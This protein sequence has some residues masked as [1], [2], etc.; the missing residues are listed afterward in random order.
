[1]QS[2]VSTDP[3]AAAGNNAN[4]SRKD[5]SL[6]VLTEN[7]LRLFEALPETEL[8]LDDVV[9]KL[10]VERR[11]IY[12]ILNVL[13][14]VFMVT[15][16]R[17]NRYRWLGTQSLSRALLCLREGLNPLDSTL[18][19]DEV[20]CRIVHAEDSSTPGKDERDYAFAPFFIDTSSSNPHNANRE[21]SLSQMTQMFVCLFMAFGMNRMSMEF[22]ASKLVEEDK[23][24]KSMLIDLPSTAA[25]PTPLP[26]LTASTPNTTIPAADAE[27]KTRT[28]TRLRRLYDIGN[29]LSALGIVKKVSTSAARPGFL[30]LC[31]A[32]LV[33]SPS[34]PLLEALHMAG[35]PMEAVNAH[36]APF[37]VPPSL[38]Q[39][40]DESETLSQSRKR[41]A[42]AISSA[43]G[44]QL[45]DTDLNVGDNDLRNVAVVSQWVAEIKLIA[46]QAKRSKLMAMP[47][48][49]SQSLQASMSG[50]SSS[51]SSSLPS[52]S[53]SSSFGALP[54]GCSVVQPLLPTSAS[55]SS[56]TKPVTYASAVGSSSSSSSSSSLN[57]PSSDVS[58]SMAR[59]IVPVLRK[60]APT[61][62]V[63]PVKKTTGSTIRF[64]FADVPVPAQQPATSTTMTLGMGIGLGAGF[65]P[66]S[67]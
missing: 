39:S 64:S 9:S 20:N 63:L 28:K 59:P 66:F 62:P 8:S 46:P 29:I 61:Q 14:A 55:S 31:D 60:A 19:F 26:G 67:K 4:A 65:R 1:M 57:A 43:S 32:A 34:R 17:K 5:K 21:K 35:V 25:P 49:S 44:S 7:F 50:S 45:P 54:P 18:V 42:D 23:D 22:A 56:V 37:V 24:E 10:Q 52:A 2:D 30:W 12:D 15:K 33:A 51:T 53:S 11:R 27:E 3:P 38:S 41:S 40:S 36:A 6:S 48:M 16:L 58:S 47:L 13:E